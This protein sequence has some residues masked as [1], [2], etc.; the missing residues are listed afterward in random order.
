MIR[1]TRTGRVGR[2]TL[3]AINKAHAGQGDCHAF[4]SRSRGNW[5]FTASESRAIRTT[6]GTRPGVASHEA[7]GRLARSVLTRP[8]NGSLPDYRRPSDQILRLC[9]TNP[10]DHQLCILGVTCGHVKMGRLGSRPCRAACQRNS[11]TGR[12][13]V[14]DTARA[15]SVVECVIRQH[16]AGTRRVQER[17]NGRAHA[18][19]ATHF[20]R[21][22]SGQRC[23]RMTPCA[24]PGSHDR[25][26]GHG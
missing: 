9:R 25:G 5:R 17:E 4:V 16:T 1:R 21:P 13:L 24:R 26:V 12:C 18:A 22:I 20:K 11:V 23:S 8:D 19:L 10:F 3:A 6:S 15:S 2:P 14:S 7:Q